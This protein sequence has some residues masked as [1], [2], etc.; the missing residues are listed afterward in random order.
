MD[1][2]F[3]EENRKNYMMHCIDKYEFIICK[4]VITKLINWIAIKD[5]CGFSE[6]LYT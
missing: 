3:S 6:H 4:E 2:A 1:R 5:M